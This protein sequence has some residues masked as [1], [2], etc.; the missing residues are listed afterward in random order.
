MFPERD[1]AGI[2]T[3]LTAFHDTIAR[4][5]TRFLRIVAVGL[6]VAEDF[7]DSMNQ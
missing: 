1:V 3:V 7:F 5:Q 4:L 6:G 2:T